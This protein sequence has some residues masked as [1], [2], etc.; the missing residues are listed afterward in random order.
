MS[1]DIRRRYFR[2]WLLD[3]IEA[4]RV[5]PEKAMKYINIAYDKAI[6]MQRMMKICL[7]LPRSNKWILLAVT[8]H[9]VRMVEQITVEFN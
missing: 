9:V 1:H 4:G 2:D 7:N 8:D 3:L 6:P 5:E